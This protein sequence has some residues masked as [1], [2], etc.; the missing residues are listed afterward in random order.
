MNA[1]LTAVAK[2][3][4][5]AADSAIEE[6]RVFEFV[7]DETAHDDELQEQMEAE[8]STAFTSVQNEL[9]KEFGDPVSTGE[10]ENDLI[11][12]NGVFRFAIWN[13]NG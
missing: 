2:R 1:S 3:L 6:V 4:L 12:L 11:P 13:I 5:A 7:D 10:E 9:S 8:F